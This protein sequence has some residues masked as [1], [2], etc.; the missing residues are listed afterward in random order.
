MSDVS[1]L[2]HEYQSTSELSQAIN[3]SL[4]VLKKVVFG[5]PGA[6]NVV[7]AQVRGCRSRLADIL[8]ILGK[9]LDAQRAM[10]VTVSQAL[11]IPG[12]VVERLKKER[13]GDLASYLHDLENL[14][15]RL[16]T[17]F[18]QLTSADFV[19][20]DHLAAI[21]DAETS[22]VFRQMMRR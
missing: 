9:L 12:A 22:G 2:S 16:R 15:A 21:A 10:S 3:T 11:T 5:L 1:V 7:A 6:E 13:N 19:T 8:E 14:A 18:P 20:L 17:D 4:I